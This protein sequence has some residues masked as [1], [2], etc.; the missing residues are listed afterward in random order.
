MAKTKDNGRAARIE[1]YRKISTDVDDLASSGKVKEGL[2]ILKE[3]QS[4]ARKFVSV[5][6]NFPV[7]YNFPI[8]SCLLDVIILV[9]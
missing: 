1:E 3:W 6:Y 9:R 7:V 2:A 5:A 4:K 8:E